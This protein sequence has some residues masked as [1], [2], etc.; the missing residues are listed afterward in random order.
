MIRSAYDAWNAG[1]AETLQGLAHPDVEVE[2]LLGNVV[3]S[4]PWTGHRGVRRLLDESGRFWARLAGRPD[5]FV[6]VGDV[7]VAYATVEAQ[8]S[9]DGP[10]LSGEVAHLFAF[11]DGLIV[12]FVAYRDRDAAI[13]AAEAPGA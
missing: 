4:G 9:D 5:D 6:E 7:V 11:R 12:R 10:V 8:V 13:A 3:S 1:D 2:P